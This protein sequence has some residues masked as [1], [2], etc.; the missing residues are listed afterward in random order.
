M[1]T[2]SLSSPNAL[3]LFPRITKKPPLLPPTPPLAGA[4]SRSPFLSRR[5][6]SSFAY[7]PLRYTVERQGTALTKGKMNRSGGVGAVCYAGPLTARNLQW[8]STISSAVLMLVKGTPVQKS[9]LVP[10]F[11]LQ[12]PSSIISW[13]KGEYGIWAAFLALLVRLFFYIPGMLTTYA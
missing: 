3:S 11:A 13:M 6:S 12:A 7:N 8:I 2:L 1:A 10:L 5:P 9:F 4:R